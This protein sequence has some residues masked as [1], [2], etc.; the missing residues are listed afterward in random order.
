MWQIT[1]TLD[2]LIFGLFGE[3]SSIL[4]FV[5]KKKINILYRHILIVK[6]YSLKENY[7][8]KCLVLYGT[9]DVKIIL[10]TF[11]TVIFGISKQLKK[12]CESQPMF[13]FLIS[14]TLSSYVIYLQ[15]M[16]CSDVIMI[17]ESFCYIA[18]FILLNFFY[19]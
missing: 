4:W 13:V 3:Y 10:Q 17:L 6:I 7:A 16:Q 11:V 9:A 15:F 5:W 12:K 2:P 8:N 14:M 1:Q 19:L 18:L